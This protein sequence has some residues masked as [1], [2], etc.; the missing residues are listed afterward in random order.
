MGNK[1]LKSLNL[2]SLKLYGSDITDE[3]LKF[4]KNLKMLDLCC[5]T[6]IT[7]KG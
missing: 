2:T 7:N 1:D 4:C 5:N 6:I 3:G